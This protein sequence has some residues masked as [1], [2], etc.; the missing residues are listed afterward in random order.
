MS[1]SFLVLFFKKEQLFLSL[2]S[3]YQKTIT[4]PHAAPGSDA[5]YPRLAPAL[6]M[7]VDDMT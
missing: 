3:V 2:S 6:A 5:V 7:T 4:P 1:K